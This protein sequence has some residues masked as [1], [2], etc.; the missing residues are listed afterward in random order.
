MESI[1]IHMYSTCNV[2]SHTFTFSNERWAELFLPL[3]AE[4]RVMDDLWLSLLL[5]QLVSSIYRQKVILK[6][7]QFAFF[8]ARIVA[9][10]SKVFGIKNVQ[11]YLMFVAFVR[12]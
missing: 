9:F 8:N 1:N 12:L 11:M 2:V 5:L 3:R 10:F 7:C 6:C 4:N